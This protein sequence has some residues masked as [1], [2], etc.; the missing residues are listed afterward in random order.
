MSWYKNISAFKLL[1]KIDE[2][3]L[4]N[5][6]EMEPI[7][8]TEL[9]KTGWSQIFDNGELF[10]KVSESFMFQLQVD[11]KKVPPSLIKKRVNDKIK[12]IKDSG[13]EKV[14]K[15]GI[16]ADIIYDLSK[17]ALVDTK[18]I[19]GYIDN[20]NKIIVVDTTSSAQAD[21][22]IAHLKASIAFKIE[23]IEPE[24]E[25]VDLMT[26]W[27]ISKEADQPFGLQDACTL[28]ELDTGS[29]TTYKS[30]DLSSDEIQE[31]LQSGKRVSQLKLDW[32]ERFVFNLTSE[33]KIKSIKP[34]SM[35][36]DLI[37]DDVG[38]DVNLV[39][40]YIASMTIMVED[41]AELLTDI[42]SKGKQSTNEINTGSD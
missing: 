3:E 12:E 34:E 13:V 26:N 35:I 42:L 19:N 27:V 36:K 20:K 18:Y 29:T 28:T 25:P 41:F 10:C 33:F 7:G 21:I 6:V 9:E 14:D 1:E 16:T 31:N 30:Q 2:K 24:F 38:E 15:K 17:K 4:L 22:F 32:H 11:K 40:V 8:A 5:L 39:S 23:M 37:E